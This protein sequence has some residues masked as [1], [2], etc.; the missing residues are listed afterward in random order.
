MPGGVSGSREKA[1]PSSIT[2][3]FPTISASPA[4]TTG[5]RLSFTTSAWISSSVSFQCS[6][7]V[8]WKR[9]FAFG[10]VGTKRPF[11]SRVFQPTWSTCMWVQKT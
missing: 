11:S 7:S 10:K 3:S 6:H 5:S 8:R 4:S 2:W 1:H 9:Y